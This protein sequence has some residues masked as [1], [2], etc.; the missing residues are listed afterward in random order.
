MR[1]EVVNKHI[2]VT[3]AMRNIIK[4]GYLIVYRVDGQTNHPGK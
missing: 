3:A 1:R 4:V 2:C